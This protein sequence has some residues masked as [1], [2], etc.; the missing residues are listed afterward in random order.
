MLMVSHGEQFPEWDGEREGERREGREEV[1]RVQT[2][3]E[4]DTE[5]PLLL[6]ALSPEKRL[7]LNRKLVASTTLASQC[8]PGITCSRPLCN[9]S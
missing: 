2:L 5:G 4:V 8:S 3:S 7:S 6:S 1:L 9:G